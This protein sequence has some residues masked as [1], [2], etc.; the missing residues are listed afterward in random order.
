LGAHSVGAPHVRQRLF[1]VA[2]GRQPRNGNLQPGRQY[3]QQPPD[4]GAISRLGDPESARLE[5]RTGERR[6]DGAQRPPAER[7]GNDARRL[8]DPESEQMGRARQ[9]WQDSV[10]LPCLDGKARR[11]ESSIQPLAYAGEW[12][13]GSRVGILRGAGNAIVPEAAAEFVRAFLEIAP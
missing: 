4:G 7:A 9:S 8:G 10:W 5:E 2:D 13:S 6:Y 3:G 11:V 1:W 12:G